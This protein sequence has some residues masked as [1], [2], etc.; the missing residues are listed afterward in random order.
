MPEVKIYPCMKVFAVMIPAAAWLFASSWNTVW[1]G[2]GKI[3]HLEM[4]SLALA[5][6]FAIVFPVAICYGVYVRFIR[7]DQMLFSETGM[8]DNIS[9]ARLGEVHW[10]NIED[11]DFKI[12]P[13]CSSLTV[14]FV[15]HA[16][17]GGKAL[18]IRL[19]VKSLNISRHDRKRIEI[20]MKGAAT[21]RA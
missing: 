18:P 7:R 20:L 2:W 1:N 6:M 5:A 11:I 10:A 15:P 9:T 13:L 16:Q 3:T 12:T 8:N 19:A 21:D 17:Q 14:D 4:Q